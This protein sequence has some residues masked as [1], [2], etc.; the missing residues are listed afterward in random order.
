MKASN[1]ETNDAVL[2]FSRDAIVRYHLVEGLAAAGEA[3]GRLDPARLQEAV[4]M[5]RDLGVIRS[6]PSVADLVFP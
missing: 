6:A 3:P 5:M 4:T 2:A 1:P